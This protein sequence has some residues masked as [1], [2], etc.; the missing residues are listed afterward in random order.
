MADEDIRHAVQ[1]PS[2]QTL[3]TDPDTGDVRQFLIGPAT[4]GRPLEIVVLDPFTD[5]ATVIHAMPAR[6]K[7]LR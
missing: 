2:R 3:Q 7:F 5:D 6:D 1:T 4:D